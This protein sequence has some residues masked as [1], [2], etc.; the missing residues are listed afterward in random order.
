MR[1]A[2]KWEAKLR[3]GQAPCKGRTTWQELRTRFERKHLRSKRQSTVESYTTALNHF[4]RVI[5]PKRL[6]T[7]TKAMVTDFADKLLDDGLST[8]TVANYLRHL[9]AA[10][11]WAEDDGLL[12]VAP[13][14]K[15][16]KGRTMK[17]RLL[18]GE[19]LTACWRRCRRCESV[20]RNGG[21]ISSEASG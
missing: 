17:G 9:K 20:T 13:K 12:A 6:A 19:S 15:F 14:F 8:S 1:F 16:E 18:A 7:V 4:E 10:L 21:N 2:A 5:G 3:A 11:R